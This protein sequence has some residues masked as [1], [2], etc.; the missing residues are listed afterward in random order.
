MH[1]KSGVIDHGRTAL[2]ANEF[3]AMAKPH[4]STEVDVLLVGAGIMSATLA[5]LLRELDPELRIGI[6]EVLESPALESSNP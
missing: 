5:T 4:F 2:D 3:P 6:Y 1:I